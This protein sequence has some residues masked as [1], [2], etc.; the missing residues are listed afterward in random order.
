MLQVGL[1]RRKRLLGALEIARQQCLRQLAERLDYGVG[2]LSG[3]R[4]LGPFRLMMVAVAMASNLGCILLQVL[5]KSCEI[6]LRRL[7][8]PRL[9]VLP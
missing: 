2:L 6:L 7:E 5:L 1:E 4:I 9:E 8:V 3:R